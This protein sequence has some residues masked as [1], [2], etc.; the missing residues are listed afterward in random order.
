M[1]VMTTLQLVSWLQQ[2][3]EDIGLWLREVFRVWQDVIDPLH[4]IE[5]YVITPQPTGMAATDPGDVHI[6]LAQQR[7][8][9]N[10][11]VL[12]T[13]V[14]DT[15]AY[16]IACF[17][18]AMAVKRDVIRAIGMEQLCYD[19]PVQFDC[20]VWFLGYMMTDL[21]PTLT[22]HGNGIL[23]SLRTPTVPI[24][25][26]T[27]AVLNPQVISDTG[28]TIQRDADIN[29]EPDDSATLQIQLVGSN[30]REREA[31][32][33][34]NHTETIRSSPSR[35]VILLEDHIDGKCERTGLPS[36][37]VTVPGVQALSQ[38]LID[39]D[40]TLQRVLPS[41]VDQPPWLQAA[42]QQLQSQPRQ[43]DI[44][45]I[46]V[47]TDGSYLWNQH[48]WK[49]TV[50]WAFCVVAHTS[51]GDCILGYRS[52]QLAPEDCL[53]F[54][55]GLL[56]KDRHEP[57]AT[58]A[59]MFA[60]L[61]AMRWLA[62]S[63]DF[64]SGIPCILIA[65]AF[66]VL[67]AIVGA[68]SMF[69]REAVTSALRPLWIALEYMGSLHSRWQ[70]AHCG[71][72]YNEIADSL[73]KEA[74]RRGQPS[75]HDLQQLQS[76]WSA[77]PWLWLLWQDSFHNTG[78]WFETDNM[79]VPI[80]APLQSR[81]LQAWPKAT[82]QGKGTMR[83]KI[84]VATY[85]VSTMYG[86]AKARQTNQRWTS[87]VDLMLPQCQHHHVI[88]FQETRCRKEQTWSKNDFFCIDSQAKD[89]QGGCALWFN[90]VLPFAKI[91]SNESEGSPVRFEPKALTVIY[92][93]HRILIVKYDTVMWQ[94]IFV[95]AHAPH[96]HTT[97]QER[98][99]FWQQLH[100][101]LHPFAKWPI[102]T[103]IDANGRTGTCPDQHIGSYQ[104]EEENQ[105][106]HALRIFASRLQLFAP[107]TFQE[108][109][110]DNPETPGGTW[111]CKDQWY[112]I[113]YV[114]FPCCWK[115]ARW[116]HEKGCLDI[117][118]VNEDH[119]SATTTCQ[120]ELELENC[121]SVQN[122]EVTYDRQ[123]LTQSQGKF[124]GS[125][126]RQRI[127]RM[128]AFW[129]QE[130]PT[131]QEQKGD[132]SPK[133]KK[134]CCEYCNAAFSSATAL[135]VHQKK[136]HSVAAQVR[137]YMH[138]PTE[139]QS[140]LVDFHTTQR[141]RQHLQHKPDQCLAHLQSVLQPMTADDIKVQQKQTS[142]RMAAVRVQGP[143]LPSRQEWAQVRSRP[144]P[145][146]E[147]QGDD[148]QMWA[149][150][151][152]NSWDPHR[153]DSWTF[154]DM[155]IRFVHRQSVDESEVAQP[156]PTAELQ[157][158]FRVILWLE[159]SQTLLPRMKEAWEYVVQMY[160]ANVHLLSIG[161]KG[162]TGLQDVSMPQNRAFWKRMIAD[163]RVIAILAAPFGYTWN[164]CGNKVSSRTRQFP[165]GELEVIPRKC[166]AIHE[167]NVSAMTYV[168]LQRAGRFHGLPIVTATSADYVWGQDFRLLE[169]G[170]H[171]FHAHFQQY[172]IGATG[173]LA[174][175][176]E[177]CTA[178]EEC[179]QRWKGVAST[180]KADPAPFLHTVIAEALL[181]QWCQLSRAAQFCSDST[182]AGHLRRSHLMLRV[183]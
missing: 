109:S 62:C 38:W 138:H 139:C 178:F 9:Q 41:A 90:T 53:M 15:N 54:E 116:H 93:S 172:E 56:A 55:G 155:I 33:Q 150:W 17:L 14:T 64:Q 86:W 84:T 29:D 99:Q 71:Q 127:A 160:N 182:F 170:T 97:Q 75:I 57:D 118:N 70:K 50:G 66:P 88:A 98:A 133:E 173:H 4:P 142:Y 26:A 45:A 167:D 83:L 79:Q 176:V 77:L 141:L 95:A 156:S 171:Q 74:A 63:P 168:D 82:E 32:P 6:V 27:N 104:S 148:H 20:T 166:D 49:G 22:L 16:N 129:R 96:E 43:S 76:E 158:H 72:V 89:G 12:I 1:E 23:V 110:A 113:D 145:R 80:P 102:I 144:M 165:L 87:R 61:Q 37:S 81:D 159:S 161:T 108:C 44:Q 60:I 146:L 134:F 105:N 8:E 121:R 114:L 154:P 115:P 13:V 35:V 120:V 119:I 91:R 92:S 48:Y 42:W 131:V 58:T 117:G 157:I 31:T 52:G 94:S 111:K 5:T 68:W 140:C 169:A 2:I 153:E 25:T 101:L 3:R 177:R 30:P 18:P 73:A 19:H 147:F 125:E 65:D 112:R 100:D 85:N 136:M 149:D 163:G 143:L 174:F 162:F 152:H 51:C 126:Q 28:G 40:P 180:R 78:P 59:E 34:A 67:Q 132:D 11:A 7:L 183:Q 107:C 151:L 39:G 181:Q 103:A 137:L 164:H 47:Y 36:Q 123:M 24:V 179:L 135:S 122:R 21:L 46:T 124:V 128:Q 106:G 175:Y 10:R 69:S 130:G